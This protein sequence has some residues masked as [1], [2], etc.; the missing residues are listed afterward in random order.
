LKKIDSI[1]YFYRLKPRKKNWNEDNI[2]LD[3]GKKYYEL[4]YIQ[5]K[6]LEKEVD[7]FFIFRD[8]KTLIKMGLLWSDTNK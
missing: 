7:T 6:F 5:D 2:E 8:I 1:R 3:I 4:S